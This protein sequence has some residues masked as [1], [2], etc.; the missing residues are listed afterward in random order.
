M[1]KFFIQGNLADVC[2]G[3]KTT[4][5]AQDANFKAQLNAV[6]KLAPPPQRVTAP[7]PAKSAP[8]VKPSGGKGS[9]LGTNRN[10]RFGG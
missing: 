3:L 10:R 6:V 2:A 8:A 7:P 1:A 9:L 5:D 4:L